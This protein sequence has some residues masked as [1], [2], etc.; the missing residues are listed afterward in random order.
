MIVKNIT[1]N[2]IITSD[3][4]EAKSVFEKSF[5]LIGFKSSKSLMLRTRFGIHTLFLEKIIDVL[6]LDDNYI[7]R[8]ALG[9]KPNRLLIYR[10]SYK[11]VIELPQ[12]SIK[13]SKTQI[14]DT[15]SM[16]K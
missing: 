13:K 14:G 5:G 16:L 10:P 1:R 2:T 8:K 11:I 12:G 6:V 9:L 4:K 3:L 15:L 7:I